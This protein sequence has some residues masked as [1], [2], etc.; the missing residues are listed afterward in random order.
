MYENVTRLKRLIVA[1]LALLIEYSLSF[2]KREYWVKKWFEVAYFVLVC[3]RT[4]GPL[5]PVLKKF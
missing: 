4:A 1:K 3:Q 2:M 5:G